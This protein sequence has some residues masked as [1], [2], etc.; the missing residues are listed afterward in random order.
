VLRGGSWS[1]NQS[2]ARCASRNGYNPGNRHVDS[3]MQIARLF[4]S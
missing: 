1:S 4:S 3:G 2:I